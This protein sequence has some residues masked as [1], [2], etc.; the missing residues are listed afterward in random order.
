MKDYTKV[1]SKFIKE[2]IKNADWK[3]DKAYID[4]L[5]F[6]E[7]IIT[8]K[9]KLGW[10]TSFKWNGSK[11]TPEYKIIYQELDPNG[12]KQ[13]KSA[14]RKEKEEEAKERAIDRKE[15]REEREKEKKAWIKAGGKVK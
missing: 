10:M 4:G 13:S 8:G 7:N 5:I 3:K 1:K 9:E 11:D 14:E 2:K 6:L 12:Y 15:E